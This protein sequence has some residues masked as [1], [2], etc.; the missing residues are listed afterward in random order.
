MGRARVGAAARRG[1]AARA[2]L[3]GH[4]LG[5][6]AAPRADRAPRNLGARGAAAA[7]LAR[8]A[9]AARYPPG[10][11]RRARPRDRDRA[12][13]PAARGERGARR[14]VARRRR[15]D[16]ARAPRPARQD[17]R[18]P[19]LRRG[20]DADDRR[21]GCRVGRPDPRHAAGA[22]R[23]AHRQAPGRG[24][25][26]PPAGGRDR[27]RL[28]EGRARAALA[29]PRIRRGAAGRPAAARLRPRR[30]ALV[31]PRRARLPLQARADPRGRV[32]GALEVRP[33]RASR[34]VRRLAEGAHRRRTARDPRV[35][36]R[37]SGRP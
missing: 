28:L 7:R 12:R 30:A 35:P 19:A 27:P 23:R 21:G 18:Q 17:R 2:G 13:I 10:L 15:A 29:R 36:P 34:R 33:R 32:L 8:A 20:D 22:D 4:P 26:D 3:R 31:D 37:P 6:G 5:R 24:E 25:V 1:A 11:G 9:G 14:G 16:R